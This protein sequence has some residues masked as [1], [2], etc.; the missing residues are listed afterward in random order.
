MA[1]A[2][3]ASRSER[4]IALAVLLAAGILSLPVVAAFLDGESTDQLIVPVQLASMAVVGAI[5]GY[6]LP[7]VA[8][9]GSSRGR[10]VGTGVVVGIVA[11]LVGVV[12]FFLLLGG[13]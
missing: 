7:G 1:D 3:T 4:P 10:G 6:L 12:V 9:P 8:G 11:A 13:S 2:E 5:V